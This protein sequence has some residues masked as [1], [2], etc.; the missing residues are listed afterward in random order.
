MGDFRAAGILHRKCRY[1][2]K[3]PGCTAQRHRHLVLQRRWLALGQACLSRRYRPRRSWRHPWKHDPS[4]QVTGVIIWFGTRRSEVRILSIFSLQ[5]MSDTKKV[6][7]RYG[8]TWTLKKL[9]WKD[10]DA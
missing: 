10:A 7:D 9:H 8:R 5:I 3:Q 6:V 4:Q 2:T 1:A